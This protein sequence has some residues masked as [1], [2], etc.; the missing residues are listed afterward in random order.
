MILLNAIDLRVGTNTPNAGII[1]GGAGAGNDGYYYKGGSS[2][3]F[4]QSLDNAKHC[5][6]NGDIFGGPVN[7]WAIYDIN[8]GSGIVSTT[9]GDWPWLVSWPSGVTVRKAAIQATAAIE[10]SDS[11]VFYVYSPITISRAITGPKQLVKYGLETLTLSGIHTYT[12]TTTI[13]AGTLAIVG[14]L[15]SGSYN[16]AIRNNGT[17]VFSSS[18]PQTL[19]GNI[20]GSGKPKVTRRLS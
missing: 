16:G 17:L 1:V 19:T 3:S 5:D 12:G 4:I 2:S 18:T 15:G 20:S 13:S 6:K 14:S 7:S 11:S 9:V 10:N 8:G